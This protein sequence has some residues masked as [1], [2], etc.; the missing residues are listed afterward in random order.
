[1]S[2]LEARERYWWS[3]IRQALKDGDV[4]AAESII[5]KCADETET[6]ADYDEI[7]GRL[8]ARIG[9]TFTAGCNALGDP[10]PLTKENDHE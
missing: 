2:E 3:K 4:S 5:W 8:T 1:M 6:E 10:A 9:K 7:I